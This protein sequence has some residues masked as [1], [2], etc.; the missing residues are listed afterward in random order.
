[1]SDEELLE[2]GGNNS[3]E[4]VD[5]MFGTSDMTVT[6]IKEDGS[7]VTVFANGNFAI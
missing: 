4:H 1:M 7:E 2:V 5:F 3:M 6:G